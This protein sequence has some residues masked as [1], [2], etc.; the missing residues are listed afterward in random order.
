MRR[1]TLAAVSPEDLAAIIRKLV[2]LAKQG[3]IAAAKIVLERT[4][5][6]AVVIDLVARLEALEQLAGVG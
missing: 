6:P 2:R 4:L 3:D 5:G 1:A